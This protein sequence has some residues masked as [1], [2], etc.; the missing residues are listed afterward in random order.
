[1][2]KSRATLLLFACVQALVTTEAVAEKAPFTASPELRALFFATGDDGEVLIDDVATEYFEGLPAQ[3]KEFFNQAVE[4]EL[5]SEPS[6]LR[7]ILRL[8]LPV[9]KLELLM[10][11]SCVVCHTNP[12]E[13]DEETLFSSDPKSV[14]SPPHLNLKEFVSDVHFRRG[15]SCAGCHGGSPDDD[16]MA[17]EIYERWPEAPERHEDRTWIPEFCARCH[18]DPAFMR[19]FNPGLATDQYAKYEESRHGLLLLGKGDSKAAQCVSCHGVHG[20]RGPRSPRSSV[21]PQQVPYTCGQCHG[22][23]DY[24]R[25]YLKADGEP[26]PTDQLER[27]EGSVHGL[28]LLERGDL[29]APACNDCHG[30]HAAMPPEVSSVSQVCR[31]CHA[32]NGEL[33]DGS[34]HKQVFDENGWPECAKC[35][36]NHGVSRTDDS[37]LNEVSDP[38]CYECHREHAANNPECTRTAEYFHASIT[39]LADASHSLGGSVHALA[40]KGLDVDPLI[41][42]VEELGDYLRQARSRIHTFERSEFDDV[43]ALGREAV[44]KGREL[45]DA[46]EAEYRF[47]RNGLMVSLAFMVLLA[48]AIYLKIRE[49]ESR[50]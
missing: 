35:H 3:A 46:A 25:G 28:A 36:G 18:A 48:V 15:L 8:D 14:G 50:D 32:G 30:N 39:A 44:E 4:A 43:A 45:I 21:H 38:L 16:T 26:L 20:I 11:D 47:R 23:A 24:M 42:T 41:A 33:F 9:G 37:M 49:L 19:R 10:R 17:D 40:E 22:D 1:V 2:R 31:S 34:K 12:D 13:H 7:E 29:G 6:H 27:F 5:M